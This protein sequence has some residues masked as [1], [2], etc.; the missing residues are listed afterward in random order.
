LF[1]KNILASKQN[2]IKLTD[3]SKYLKKHIIEL[4]CLE[5]QDGSKHSLIEYRTKFTN[6]HYSRPSQGLLVEKIVPKLNSI[7]SVFANNT[8]LGYNVPVDI[9]APGTSVVYRDIVDFLLTNEEEEIIVCEIDDLSDF[10][11]F[12]RKLKYWPQYYIPYSYLANKFNKKVSV[13]IIDPVNFTTLE[14]KYLPD[15]FIGDLHQISDLAKSMSTGTLIRT[16]NDC[17]ECD[18]KEHCK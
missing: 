17:S 6:K 16:F 18:K 9:G 13:S 12:Q 5:M 8:F 7:F 3:M 1:G 11:G 10:E 4:A 2:T 15:R 14:A